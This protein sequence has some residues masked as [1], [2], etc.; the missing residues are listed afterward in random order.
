MDFHSRRLVLIR[1]PND[2]FENFF[3]PDRNSLL[4]FAFLEKRRKSTPLPSPVKSNR[5][6]TMT[7]KLLEDAIVFH[8]C[9]MEVS[10][11][12]PTFC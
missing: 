2:I 4:P 5:E 9:F 6:F 10:G 3:L 7:V 12:L 11:T 1:M 8:D